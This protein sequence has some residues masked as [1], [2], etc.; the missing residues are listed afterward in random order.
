MRIRNMREINSDI[1]NIMHH[2]RVH[3]TWVFENSTKIFE[4][5]ATSTELVGILRMAFL[6]NS[7]QSSYT[8]PFKYTK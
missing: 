2:R 1:N 8:I 7:N 4:S 3:N 6:K 5:L